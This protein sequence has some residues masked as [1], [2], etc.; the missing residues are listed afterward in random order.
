[1]AANE[2]RKG[3]DSH[4]VLACVL[5]GVAALLMSLANVGVGS[6]IGGFGTLAVLASAFFVRHLGWKLLLYIPGAY[7]VALVLSFMMIPVAAQIDDS[8]GLG[9][10]SG[11][12]GW[13]R[14]IDELNAYREPLNS[15]LELLRNPSSLTDGRIQVVINAFN[16]D[17]ETWSASDP[18]E[19]ARALNDQMIVVLQGWISVFDAVRDG[20]YSDQL[21]Y[22]LQVEDDE[23][24]RL[25]REANAT[26]AS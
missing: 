3:T 24:E 7:V 19:N 1:M 10:R 16:N 14:Y 6:S 25:T 21:L 5:V 11:C 26:C 23:L 15:R 13:N 9:S 18:P 20:T 8:T 2:D 17:I 22:D 4:W 12:A